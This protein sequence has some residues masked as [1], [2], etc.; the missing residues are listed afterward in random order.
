MY[1]TE[2]KIMFI[3]W[4]IPLPL[5][6]A[7]FEICSGCKARVRIIANPELIDS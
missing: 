2:K 6:K 4:M 7:Y 3:L 5:D 1:I